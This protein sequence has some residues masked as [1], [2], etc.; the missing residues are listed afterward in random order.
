MGGRVERSITPLTRIV[1]TLVFANPLKLA[2]DASRSPSSAVVPFLSSGKPRAAVSG[3]RGVV[4]WPQEVG[5][6]SEHPVLK[7]R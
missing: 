5:W 2:F 1:T 7:L 6:R 4:T 3:S